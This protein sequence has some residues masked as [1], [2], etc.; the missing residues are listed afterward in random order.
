M[1]NSKKAL[2]TKSIIGIFAFLENGELLHYKLFDRSV[3]VVSEALKKPIPSDF[4]REIKNYEIVEGKEAER[5]MRGKLRE[6]AIS[7]NFA[8]SNKEFNEFMSDLG[9]ALSKKSMKDSIKRDKLI[10][11]AANALDDLNKNISLFAERLYEWYTLHY[12]ENK[13]NQKDLVEF[14][15]E[16]GR[17]ERMPDFKSST[18]IDLDEKDEDILMDYADLIFQMQIQKKKLEGYVKESMREIMSNVSSLIDPLLAAKLLAMAGSLEKLAKMPASTIQ[19]LGAEK[20][21][22]RHLKKK[23]KSPKFGLIFMDSH[24][25]NAPDDKKGKAARILSSKLMLAAR[26]DFYSGRHE[27]KLKDDLEEE[28][29]VI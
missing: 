19:L 6:Y 21:L 15:A 1:M 29:K 27:E 14:V 28:L 20:A 9:L 11:Q 3:N 12:P 10:I 5:I 8:S 22:F 17:R 16:H 23:G 26:I 18:G 2:V 13:L 7:L 24:I 4:L 25:Q